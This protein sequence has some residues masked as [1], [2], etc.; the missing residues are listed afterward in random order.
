MNHISSLTVTRQYIE[1]QVRQATQQNTDDILQ[2]ILS[3]M[4]AVDERFKTQEL[5][6]NKVHQQIQSQQSE[7]GLQ[8]GD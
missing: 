3:M 7:D 2:I 1:H 8:V 6:M 4:A 5:A